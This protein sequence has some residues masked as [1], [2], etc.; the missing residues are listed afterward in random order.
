MI[1]EAIIHIGMHKTGSSSI[2]ETFS[3]LKMPGVEYLSLGTPNHSGFMATILMDNPEG[4]HS[5][6]RRGATK[7]EV[8]RLRDCYLERFAAQLA[9]VKEKRII[10][11]AE[12]LSH[13]SC[14]EKQLL[15]LKE[16][17]EPWCLKFF[18]IGYV[19]PPIG[20]MQSAFQQKLKS[21]AELSM[22][23]DKIYPYY[24]A[25]F[26][27]FFNVFG[28]DS[29]ELVK[30]DRT[31][32]LHGDVVRD[33]SS[34]LGVQL[35]PDEI[36]STNETMSLEAVSL[37]FF[38]RK[39]YSISQGY[40]KYH[41]DNARLLDNL[42][43][44]GDN[45]F[46]FSHSLVGDVVESHK[47]DID[48]ISGK[49]GC[50]ILDSEGASCF[51]ITRAEDFRLSA[52]HCFPDLVGAVLDVYKEDDEVR[53]VAKLVGDLFF[54][55]VGNF[56]SDVCSNYSFFSD[57]QIESIRC[58]ESPSDVLSV[59][60]VALQSHGYLKASSVVVS[61]CHQAQRIERDI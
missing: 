29:V 10:I 18:V 51:A 39:F 31:S 7:T 42:A 35:N 25:R 55:Q 40:K 32:L 22:E 45:K 30:Y 13:C 15:K 20:F 27:S 53:F 6:V 47:L 50:S 4:H 24:E 16:I 33:F 26:S 58:S 59:L 44:I 37:L 2:Q 23:M 57:A 19:R 48:W 11:S 14:G 5:H 1:D 46:L 28:R 9:S 17:L 43:L 60:S 54:L 52:K 8:Y 41:V 49:L 3:R 12:Y 34:R 36:I 61:A 56:K 38:H 21:G